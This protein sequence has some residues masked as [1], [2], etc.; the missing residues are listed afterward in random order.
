[1]ILAIVAPNAT[2]APMIK[3]DE[4][5]V[6]SIFIAANE[7]INTFEGPKNG[8]ILNAKDVMR[9]IMAS[10]IVSIFCLVPPS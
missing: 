7:A 4:K 1:M 8:I 2:R 5:F 6:L 10:N 9:T 3:T